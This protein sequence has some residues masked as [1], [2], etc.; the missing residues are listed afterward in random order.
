MNVFFQMIFKN[1]FTK[2][3]EIEF[4]YSSGLSKRIIF[5]KISLTGHFFLGVALKGEFEILGRLVA[6]YSTFNVKKSDRAFF[7][8]TY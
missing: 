5:P 3:I 8:K 7:F 6:T 2:V 4:V 1:K